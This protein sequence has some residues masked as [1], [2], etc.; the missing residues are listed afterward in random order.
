M[1]T[2]QRVKL[3]ILDSSF[4]KLLF[5]LCNLIFMGYKSPFI[6]FIQVF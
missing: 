3:G 4:N 6:L 5:S 2:V 1:F